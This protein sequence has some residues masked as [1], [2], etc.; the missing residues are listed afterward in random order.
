MTIP[1]IHISFRQELDK[2][3][4]FEYP[5]FLA[6]QI[7]YWL[8]KAQLELVN[9]LAYPEG[10][11]NYGFENGQKRVD[12]LRELVTE[13]L[14][15]L[16]ITKVN[17]DYLAELPSNYFHLLNHECTTFDS[18]C[19]R[20]A[21]V[22]GIQTKL[23]YIKFKKQDPFW[24]PTS[25]EPLYYLRQNNIVYETLGDFEITST[26]ISYIRVPAKMQNGQEYVVPAPN[27]ECEFIQE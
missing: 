8:N 16:S 10:N 9:Y 24:K 27:I 2:T 4:D 5:S 17:N 25:V 6:E 13:P 15:S 20:T 23:D 7:D 26:N 3:Q 11:S 22:A 18:D 14:T 12:D 19:N 21:T 1:E